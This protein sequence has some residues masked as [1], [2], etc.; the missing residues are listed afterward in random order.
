MTA[1][2]RVFEPASLSNRPRNRGRPQRSG[3]I[4]DRCCMR[5]GLRKLIEGDDYRVDAS[6]VATAM[7]MRALALR[8]ARAA[9]GS[10][11]L[12]AAEEIEVHRLR[13]AEGE[14]VPL[15]GTA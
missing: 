11:M 10:A 9:D 2:P 5:D 15:E 1:V 8:T 3:A 12:V 13:P 6:A 7:L 4:A 14:S